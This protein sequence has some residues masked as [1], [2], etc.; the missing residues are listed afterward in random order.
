MVLS[1][2]GWMSLVDRFGV[3]AATLGRD[4]LSIRYRMEITC[5]P[6]GE[7]WGCGLQVCGPVMAL[8]EADR[9]TPVP[10]RDSF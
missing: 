7:R 8:A 3:V 9:R 1:A 4:V 5:P 6:L 10:V 2:P